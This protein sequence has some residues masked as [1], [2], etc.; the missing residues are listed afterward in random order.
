MQGLLLVQQQAFLQT[1]FQQVTELEAVA[2]RTI[3]TL[4]RTSQQQ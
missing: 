3:S 1:H 2:A 4:V